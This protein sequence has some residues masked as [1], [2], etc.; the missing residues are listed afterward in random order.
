VLFFLLY[1]FR[2]HWHWPQLINRE[3]LGGNGGGG[4]S[5]DES[6]NFGSRRASLVLTCVPQVIPFFQRVKLFQTLID[7]DKDSLGIS[8]RQ[9]FMGTGVHDVTIARET[10][11]EDALAT[12][13]R[14]GPH[15]KGR[16]RVTFDSDLG[17][18][19][20]PFFLLFLN[21]FLFRHRHR[22]HLLLS[23]NELNEFNEN[24]HAT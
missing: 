9:S 13:D 18:Q 16:I 24:E 21:S 15:L 20:T 5:S 17:Y 19:V 7:R 22:C 11:Y 23:N 6:V 1:C 3:L 12:L 4:G 8:D 10:I 2:D 14:L